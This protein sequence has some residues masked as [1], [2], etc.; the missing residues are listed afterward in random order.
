MDPGAHN[1]GEDYVKVD[2]DLACLRGD[3]LMNLG[4][5]AYHDFSRSV[6]E[7]LKPTEVDAAPF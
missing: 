2:P 6:S 3:L 5:L 7:C 4:K 1:E